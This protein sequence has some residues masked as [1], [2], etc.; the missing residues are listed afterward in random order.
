MASVT[1]SATRR[2]NAPRRGHPPWGGRA[3]VR[4]P[5]E[6]PR[7]KLGS[8]EGF[9]SLD[10]LPPA[11]WRSARL[12]SHSRCSLLHGCTPAFV[13]PLLG[14]L[15][16]FPSPQ[17]PLVQTRGA[18]ANTG[19][20]EGGVWDGGPLPHEC[21]AACCALVLFAFLT[22]PSPVEPTS[23]IKSLLSYPFTEVPLFLAGSQAVQHLTPQFLLGKQ[24]LCMRRY[25]DS[26]L[27]GGGDILRVR[28]DRR[29]GAKR[30]S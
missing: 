16:S 21:V 29:R 24:R 7:S 1:P 26:A 30:A 2:A 14:G 20:P 12:Q 22:F 6:T 18:D 11:S 8:S 27:G 17:G 3:A 5:A 13:T 9:L 4:R 28:F 10:C 19:H 23:H 15:R 25:L